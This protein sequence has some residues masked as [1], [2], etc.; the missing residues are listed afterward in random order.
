MPGLKPPDTTHPFTMLSLPSVPKGPDTG[1]RKSE[2]TWH[3]CVVW[4]KL[5]DYAATLTKGAHVR[6]EGVIRRR[7]CIQKS[8]GKK[9]AD[10]K[11]SITEVRVTASPSLTARRSPTRRA[12]RPGAVVERAEKVR[13]DLHRHQTVVVNVENSRDR[14]LRSSLREIGCR[15]RRRR[16]LLSQS[17]RAIVANTG[18]T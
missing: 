5:G 18:R 7:E 3:R 11:K 15:V 4:G 14:S 13:N 9:S 12:R 2:T 8:G 1:D 16:Q 17:S 10:V 6:I